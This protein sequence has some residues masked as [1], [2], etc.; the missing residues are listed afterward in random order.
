MDVYDVITISSVFLLLLKRSRFTCVWSPRWT[1][2]EWHLR[3]PAVESAF[4]KNWNQ[5]P[6]VWIRP[7]RWMPGFNRSRVWLFTR[8]LVSFSICRRF[9]P[10]VRPHTP[11]PVAFMI[12]AL[13]PD[14]SRTRCERCASCDACRATSLI[15][16]VHAPTLDNASVCDRWDEH[17]RNRTE[18]LSYISH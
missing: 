9:R 13:Y 10:M 2:S 15:H 16:H 6:L 7:S 18:H 12:S 1:G 14:E 4:F 8:V 11:S 3:R 17:E 5:R